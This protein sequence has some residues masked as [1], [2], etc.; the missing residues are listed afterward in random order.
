MMDISEEISTDSFVDEYHKMT[1]NLL[2]TSSRLTHE[3]ESRA[4]QENITL[5]QFNVL[6]ILREKYPDTCTNADI[7]ER[8]LEKK[9]DVSRIVNRMVTKGLV[10]RSKSACDGR[11]VA[12]T[13]TAKGMEILENLD[14]EMLLADLL[15]ERLSPEECDVLNDLLNRLRG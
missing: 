15:Q 4:S 8:M 1:I 2:V 5:H 10:H 9:S 6:R 12:L 3:L 7:K 14:Q 13:I 11:A